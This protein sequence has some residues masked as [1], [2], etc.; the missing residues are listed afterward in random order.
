MLYM[1]IKGTFKPNIGNPDGDSVRFKPDDPSPL[2][3]LPRQ[4]ERP[5]VRHSDGT[6]QLRYEGIDTLE[7]NAKKPFASDATK[8]NLELLGDPCKKGQTRGYILTR[9]I[10]YYGRPIAFV[11]TGSPRETEEDGTYVCLDVARMKESVNFRL[12]QAGQAYPSF[13]DTLAADLR[14]AIKNEVAAARSCKRG[15]WHYDKTRCGVTVKEALKPVNPLRE[16]DPIFP[17]LWRR[18]SDY[19]E[20][21]GV[22][23][24]SG[25]KFTLNKTFKDYLKIKEDKVLIISESRFTRLHEIVKVDG[26]TVSLSYCPE[27]LIFIS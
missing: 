20:A 22:S 13:Y 24:K 5:Y 10:G 2:F 25:K 7:R 15:I 4:W 6:I 18:L 12:I 8:K 16:L 17:K 27:D 11:F 9:L 26:N 19:K 1:L 14:E 23:K 3:D 21:E